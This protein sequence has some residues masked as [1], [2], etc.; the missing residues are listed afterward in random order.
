MTS[1][2][3][4]NEKKLCDS[5]LK[6]AGCEIYKYVS[7][8]PNDDVETCIHFIKNKWRTTDEFINVDIVKKIRAEIAAYK[9]DKIIHAE[10]NEMIDIM[11]EIIDRNTKGI[12]N[13][14]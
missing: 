14:N 11:L 4:D 8:R 6:Q 10:R 9:D 12:I 2:K 7:S 13:E 3:V 5:C 1:P